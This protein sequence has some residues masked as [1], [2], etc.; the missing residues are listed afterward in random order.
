MTDRRTFVKTAG[1]AV[2][3]LAINYTLFCERT[4][5]VYPERSHILK[6]TFV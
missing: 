5:K 1:L 4:L 2:A 6:Q 3:G